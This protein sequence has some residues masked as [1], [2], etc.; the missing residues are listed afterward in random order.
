M[1]K[2]F[3]AVILI[4]IA[5]ITVNAQQK[6]IAKKITYNVGV[7]AGLPVGYLKDYSSLMTGVSLQTEY[8]ALKKLG[9]T[10]SVNYL[11]FI[12]KRGGVKLPLIPILGGLKYYFKPKIYLSTQAGMSFYAGREKVEKGDTLRGS[13]EKYFTY[14]PGI[15]FRTS[16]RF[17]VLLKYQAVYIASSKKT[18]SSAGVR[19]GYNFN[20]NKGNK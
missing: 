8:P 3:L 7:D 5:S 17:D 14:A 18:Y 16:R 9:V 6:K 1:K 13:G 10:A 2:I 12:A 15:G 4:A 20:L 11:E 19:I